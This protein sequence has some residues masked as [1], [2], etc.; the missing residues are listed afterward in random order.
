M[1]VLFLNS[2]SPVA[3]RYLYLIAWINPE[4]WLVMLTIPPTFL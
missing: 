4:K 2:F 1:G 3:V